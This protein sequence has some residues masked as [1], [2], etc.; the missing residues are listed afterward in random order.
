LPEKNQQHFSKATGLYV[1][2]SAFL[3]SIHFY[4]FATHV[5]ELVLTKGLCHEIFHLLFLKSREQWNLTAFYLLKTMLWNSMLTKAMSSS[6]FLPE[7]IKAVSSANEKDLS[8]MPGE[9]FM[10]KKEK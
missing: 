8:F 7:V 10:C 2:F 9:S 6:T 4:P 5:T 1:T 3:P